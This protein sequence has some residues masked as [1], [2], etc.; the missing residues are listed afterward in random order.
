MNKLNLTRKKLL[1]ISMLG[2]LVSALTVVLLPFSENGSED[3]ISFVGVLIGT[4]FW[5]GIFIGV[6][7]F[8]LAWKVVKDDEQY[9]KIKE[10]KKPG[11][12]SLFSNKEAKINDSILV[13]AFVVVIIS[14]FVP[15]MPDILILLGLFFMI[16]SFCLHFILNGRVY[17]YLFNC[18]KERKEKK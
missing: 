5:I 14:V 6:A 18:K 2:F 17:K 3:T 1:V 7:F 15:M 8:I 11:Y 12:V 9:K 4:F 10:E 13:I 16:Y